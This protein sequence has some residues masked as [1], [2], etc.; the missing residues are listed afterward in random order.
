M[1][2]VAIALLVALLVAGVAAAAT[3]TG[4]ARADRLTGTARSDVIDG[5]AGADSLSGLGGGD[6]L[7]GGAGPDT[8]NAGAGDD[9]IPAHADAARDRVR[10]GAGRDI[11][12]AELTDIVAADC[13][14]VSRQ[15]SRDATTDPIGQHAT[16]VEPD[17]FAFGSTIVSVFQVGRVF[18]GGAVAIGYST[19][20]DQGTTWRNGLLPGVTDSSPQPGVAERASDPVVS[21]DAVHGIWLAVSLGISPATGEFHF[22][23][24]RSSDGITW[25]APVIAVTGRDGDL[26]KEWISCD[27]GTASPFRGHCYIAYFD[28]STGEILTTTSTDGGLTWSTPVPTSP[29]PPNGLDYNGTQPVSL[30]DGTLVVV[31]TAFASGGAFSSQ[32]VASRS[33]DGGAS[34]TAPVTV[35]PLSSAAIPD[36]RTFSLATVEADAA[37]RIYAAWEGCPTSGACF[38]SRIVMSTSTDG[39]AW[40]APASITV[41]ST[42]S[43]HFLPGLGADPST[44]GRLALVYYSVPDNCANEAGCRGVD[45]FFRTSANGGRTWTKAQRLSAET[46]P[47]D[48]IPRTR[49]G[50]ML[51][52]YVSTSYVRGRPIAIFIVA[53]PRIGGVFRQAAFAYRPRS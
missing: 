16:Q 2:R 34:F 52:D 9:R 3:I 12:T 32:I 33:L 44:Q 11:V 40:T 15:I 48:A 26:D 23:V 27:N 53:A 41:P 13:E 45:A 38:A 28:V 17:S 29:V 21:Y 8:I 22:Y 43:D 42:A 47:L 19:S 35:A 31:F 30:P 6:V 5:R 24:N 4:T 18:A 20:R 36:I 49:S 46:M 1:R 37:G 50:L 14:V 25:S 7:Q 39:V 51:A 10:C